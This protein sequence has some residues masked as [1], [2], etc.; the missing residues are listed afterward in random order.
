MAGSTVEIG[1]FRDLDGALAGH[2]GPVR[3]VK[4]AYGWLSFLPES[5]VSH[6]PIS[7]ADLY[8]SDLIVMGPALG[9]FLE[10]THEAGK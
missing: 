3:A 4:G 8:S 5:R 7:L 10:M 1:L 6:Q 9:P 2:T